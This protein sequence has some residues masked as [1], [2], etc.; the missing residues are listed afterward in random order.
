MLPLCTTGS[1]QAFCEIVDSLSLEFIM[2]Q[3]GSRGDLGS[4]EE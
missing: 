2:S 1:G 4:F 3:P